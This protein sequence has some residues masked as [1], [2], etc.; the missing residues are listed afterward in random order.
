[1]RTHTHTHSYKCTDT[2]TY[3]PTYIHTNTG[4]HTYTHTPAPDPSGHCW[5][6]TASSRLLDLNCELPIPVGTA[7]PQLPAPDPSGHCWPQ[8]PAPDLSGHQ[9]KASFAQQLV[10]TWMGPC[11]KTEAAAR[12]FSFLPYLLSPRRSAIASTRMQT[13]QASDVNVFGC[14]LLTFIAKHD[15][16]R[17]GMDLKSFTAFTTQVSQNVNL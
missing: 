10:F 12:S 3:R 16:D 11:F 1:M 17:K 14:Q 5:T 4:I 8:L 13:G 6:S 7:G 2:Y 15:V 9:S